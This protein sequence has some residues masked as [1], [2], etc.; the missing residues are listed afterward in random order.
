MIRKV[1]DIVKVHW[2]DSGASCDSCDESA[3]THF[4][5]NCESY[6]QIEL[7]DKLRLVL[8]TS[9]AVKDNGSTLQTDRLTI[10]PP[11]ITKI[12]KLHEKGDN[13]ASGSKKESAGTRRRSSVSNRK[14]RR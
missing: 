11:C 6:G 8:I 14:K 5:H 12:T 3:E 13:H 7:F 10:Y 9:R 1:G 2:I 4:L